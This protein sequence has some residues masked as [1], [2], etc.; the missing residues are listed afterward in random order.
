MDTQRRIFK[1]YKN[2]NLIGKKLNSNDV[3][4]FVYRV[5]LFRCLFDCLKFVFEDKILVTSRS[6]YIA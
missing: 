5:A 2:E 4:F 3:L 1:S 6:K